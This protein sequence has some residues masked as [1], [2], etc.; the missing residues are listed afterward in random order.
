MACVQACIANDSRTKRSAPPS[1]RPATEA[2]T[3]MTLKFALLF[4]VVCVNAASHPMYS[5]MQSEERSNALSPKAVMGKEEKPGIISKRA[6]RAA[7]EIVISSHLEIV[8]IPSFS[9]P[10]PLSFP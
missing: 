6:G 8:G 2:Q 3:L 9:P 4:C 1:P 5:S 10:P 7:A